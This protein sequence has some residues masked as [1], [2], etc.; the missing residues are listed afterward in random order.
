[1]SCR[2][3]NVQSCDEKTCRNYGVCV[4]R[5]CA[6]NVG[7]SG[8]FCE[9]E[10]TVQVPKFSRGG[11]MMVKKGGDKRRALREIS[12]KE[13]YVNFTT[14]RPNA[15]ILWS[16]KNHNFIGIGLENGFLKLVYSMEDG[17]KTVIER[18][19]FPPIND[20]LWHSIL[21]MFYPISMVIDGKHFTQEFARYPNVTTSGIFYIGN[22]PTL[23]SSLIEETH[24]MFADPFEGCIQMFGSNSEFVD[25]FSKID[26]R[27][28]ESC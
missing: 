27:N 15:L 6:C 9:K 21:V 16:Q 10:I 23:N 18:P 3:E 28:I 2:C 4:N 12:V 22:T 5:T 26:G 20:G 25:D 8:I 17:N 24:G 11:Y 13:I 14:V 19:P 7:R 1:I